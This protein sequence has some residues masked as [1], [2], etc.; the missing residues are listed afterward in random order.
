MRKGVSA[1]KLVEA[2]EEMSLTVFLARW[3]F[4]RVPFF[5][6]FPQT[7]GLAQVCS[8]IFTSVAKKPREGESAP[9]HGTKRSSLYVAR[10]GAYVVFHS[11]RCTERGSGEK[12]LPSE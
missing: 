12:M 5:G 1:P 2:C 8:A 3:F 11:I 10:Q 4:S 6:D 9:F 7:L